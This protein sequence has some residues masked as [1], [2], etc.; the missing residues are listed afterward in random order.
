L[1]FLHRRIDHA[2]YQPTHSPSD[3]A[4]HPSGRVGEPEDIA[5][6]VLFLADERNDF[7]NGENLVVDGGMSKQMIYHNDHGWSLASRQSP[8]QA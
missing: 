1:D 4:Q 6:A 7:I 5:R 8:D 2:S 3:L